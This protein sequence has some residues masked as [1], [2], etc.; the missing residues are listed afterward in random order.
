M[1][2]STTP[3]RSMMQPRAS[4]LLPSRHDVLSYLSHSLTLSD[5][6]RCVYWVGRVSELTDRKADKQMKPMRCIVLPLCLTLQC[7]VASQCLRRPLV[8]REKGGVKLF[9]GRLPREVLRSND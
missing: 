8:E 9:V 4:P 5:I 6:G 2:T 7:W 3:V 1:L